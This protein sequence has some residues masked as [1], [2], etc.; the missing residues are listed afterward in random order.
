MWYFRVILG[1]NDYNT[2]RRIYF[3]YA[4]FL[5]L[6]QQYLNP[7]VAYIRTFHLRKQIIYYKCLYNW[8]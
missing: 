2:I 3:D 4:V 8:W 5:E 6:P 1:A 7:L